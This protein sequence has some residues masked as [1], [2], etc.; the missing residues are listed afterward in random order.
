MSSPSPG[1]SGS[2]LV[3]SRTETC[4]HI[5]RDIERN[6]LEPLLE[7][8]FSISL[9]LHSNTKF[10]QPRLEWCI[11][12]VLH[13]NTTFVQPLLE[14]C[15][16][17]CCTQTLP[18][19]SPCWSDALTQCWTQTLPSC[20]PC[21]SD[22]PR[23]ATLKHMLIKLTQGRTILIQKFTLFFHALNHVNSLISCQLLDEIFWNDHYNHLNLVYLCFI[24]RT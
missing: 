24:Q 4:M 3:G 2:S 11:N 13:S 8:Y 9:V 18:S 23:S 16:T 19:C 10:M 1:L 22:A 17:Q 5:E 6:F 14:W 20:S 21:W 7:W 15:T 12:A